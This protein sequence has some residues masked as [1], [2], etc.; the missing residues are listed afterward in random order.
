[1]KMILKIKHFFM[2]HPVDD[3]KDIAPL[4]IKCKCGEIMTLSDWY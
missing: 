2:G 3:C 4:T 1:M